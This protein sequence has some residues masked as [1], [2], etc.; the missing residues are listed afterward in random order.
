MIDQFAQEDPLGQW[1]FNECIA[2]ETNETLDHS[3]IAYQKIGAEV[4]ATNQPEEVLDIMEDLSEI[5]KLSSSYPFSFDNLF[6]D[7]PPG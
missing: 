5:H 3:M 7:I 1:D 4:V 2:R 6:S